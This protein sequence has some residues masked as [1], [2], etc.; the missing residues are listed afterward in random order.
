ME[1]EQLVVSGTLLATLV[2]FVWGHW[3]YD[4]V[5][6][7]ALLFL[8]I[9]DIVPAEDAF[10][11]FGHPAIVTVVAVLVI[12]RALEISGLVDMIAGR[13][14]GLNERPDLMLACLCLLVTLF[15]AFMNNIGALALLLPV[16]IQ[17]T[18]RGSLPRHVALMPLAFGS[19]LGGMTTLIGTP[20]NIIISSY[21]EEYSGNPFSIFD[22]SPVGVVVAVFGAVLAAMLAKWLLPLRE[23]EASHDPF[24]QLEP[25]ITELSVP[26]DSPLVG[27]A[28]SE[29]EILGDGDAAVVELIRSGSL[30]LAPK[31]RTRL[32]AD[33]VIVIEA[34]P[35]TLKLILESSQ[36]ELAHEKQFNAEHLV[37]DETEIVEAVIMPGSRIA[38]RTSVEMRLRSHYGTNLLALSRK[39]ARINQRLGHERLRTGDVVLL[40]CDRDRMAETLTRLGCLP[41]TSRELTPRQKFNAV[42]ALIF[43][44]ALALGTVGLFKVYV[45]L[46]LAA[47]LLV[48]LRQISL[49]AAYESID[50]PIIVLLGAMIPVGQSLETTGVTALIAQALSAGL[51]GAPVWLV[52]LSLLL[53]SM[54]LSNIINNAA[55]AILM[56]P[57]ALAIASQLDVSSDALLMSVAVG[58][59]AAFLTPIGHQSNLLVMGPGGYNFSDYWRLGLPLSLLVCLLGVPAIFLFW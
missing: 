10:D 27:K 37:A 45:A 30:T 3:R 48:M 23:E 56:A 42:P 17:L 39:G 21:R 49:P 59:S 33:D 44:A 22:F 51:L 16:T 55:T 36:V 2:L 46:M 13:L 47:V 7:L 24:E 58:S 11:G 12:S 54:V 31:A 20:P 26:P 1:F 38:R 15:S 32:R 28:L 19:I 50:W 6:L 57:L 29:F 43:F 8:T 35:D 5:A 18:D 34:D 4:V 53:V 25:Y 52:I 41:L 14:Q 9:F 40:Q